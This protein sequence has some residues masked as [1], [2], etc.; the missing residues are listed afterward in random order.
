MTRHVHHHFDYARDGHQRKYTMHVE[1]NLTATSMAQRQLGGG[2]DGHSTVSGAQLLDHRLVAVGR[3]R[4]VVSAL[5]PVGHHVN[6]GYL[7]AV[8]LNRDHDGQ[9]IPYDSL[10][11]VTLIS[12]MRLGLTKE[13]K[14]RAYKQFIKLPLYED[15]APW[16]IV[17]QGPRLDYIDYD[18]RDVTFDRAVPLAY[19]VM[20]VLFN[21]KRTVEDFGKCGSK[22]SAGAYGFPYISDCV[23][24]DFRGPCDEPA[25][26]VPCGD[27]QC[28]PDYISCLKALVELEESRQPGTIDRSDV[29]DRFA[30]GDLLGNSQD[31]SE[32]EADLATHGLFD[33]AKNGFI[34]RED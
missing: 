21:Y 15:M 29:D 13:L 1:R 30:G 11:S 6:S 24:S 23:K 17:F 32:A 22:A 9:F 4:E 7:T 31:V 25:N 20:S 14:E 34:D 33:F 3:G 8:Y 2:N 10:Y 28:R 26:P 19:Q 18:T 5:V 12:V 16:N 27:G